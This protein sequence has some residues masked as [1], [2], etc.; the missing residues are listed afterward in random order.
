MNGLLLS[1]LS[2][3]E[4][5]QEYFFEHKA[6]NRVLMDSTAILLQITKCRYL[7]HRFV[8][9]FSAETHFLYHSMTTINFVNSENS[10]EEGNHRLLISH[11]GWIYIF[12]D[13]FGLRLDEYKKVNKRLTYENF[14]CQQ[15]IQ[16][17]L[18]PPTS[19]WC[20]LYSIYNA[21]C[22]QWLLPCNT[23]NR[24]FWFLDSFR[25]F[26]AIQ[27]DSK[28]RNSLFIVPEPEIKLSKIF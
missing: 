17:P 4:G 3:L 15:V 2:P 16:K 8:G 5:F 21:L 9:V 25:V 13:L 24:V 12:G 6:G 20:G 14:I 22:F 26:F 1:T 10:D 7:T 19:N 28:A 23:A 18:Q 27:D 11:K